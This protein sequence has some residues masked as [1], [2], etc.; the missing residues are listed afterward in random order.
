MVNLCVVYGKQGLGEDSEQISL[1]DKLLC[2][3]FAGA[4]VVCVGQPLLVAGDCIAGVILC[5]AK[6]ISSGRFVDLASAYLVGVRRE[7]HATCRFK[8]GFAN[9]LLRYLAPVR[10]TL[11]GLLVGLALPIGRPPFLGRSRTFGTSNQVEFS[12]V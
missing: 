12:A 1:T 4:Q 7:P 9:G 3:V 6:G 5:L 11:F 2:A 10:F 8:L